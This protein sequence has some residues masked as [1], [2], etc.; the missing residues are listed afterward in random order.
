MIPAHILFPVDFSERSAATASYVEAMA[1][2]YG[3][4]VTRY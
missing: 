4:T 1:K 3:S 2:Q